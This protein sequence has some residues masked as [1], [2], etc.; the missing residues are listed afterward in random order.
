MSTCVCV[1]SRYQIV[2]GENTTIDD[3]PWT[4]LLRYRHEKRQIE[5]WGCGGA[6]VGGRTIIT[7]A[8]CVDAQA[9]NDIGEMYVALPRIPVHSPISFICLLQFRLFVRLGE[10]DTENDQDC[11]EIAGQMD[12]ADPPIDFKI[13]CR[14]PGNTVH[15]RMSNSNDIHSD[16]SHFN[17]P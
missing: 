12:C 13:A 4:A 2:G 17:S 6:Y 10:F 5:S 8:H 9:V 7:A 16:F 14:Y 1:C 11:V 15:H 3:Y